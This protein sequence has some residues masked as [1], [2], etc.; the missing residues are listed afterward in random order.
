MRLTLRLGE[1]AIV[2][3]I[4]A[5]ISQNSMSVVVASQSLFGKSILTNFNSL[6]ENL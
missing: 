1:M 4:Y 6:D 3:I 2:H 5:P